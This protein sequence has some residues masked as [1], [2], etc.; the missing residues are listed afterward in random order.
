MENIRIEYLQEKHL[1]NLVQFY[2]LVFN[3]IVPPSY[4][5]IKYG[6]EVE[7]MP[8]YAT[9]IYLDDKMVGF[10]G[11]I[12]QEF[13]LEKTIKLV[14]TCDF[15]LLE[16]YRG[17]GLFKELYSGTLAKAKALNV[18]LFYGIHSVQS[19]KSCQRLG[20]E[21]EIGFSRFHIQGISP[22]ISKLVRK[23]LPNLQRK[24]LEKALKPYLIQ[25]EIDFIKNANYYEHS[26][27]ATFFEMKLFSQ[28]YWVMIKNIVLCIKLES[29]ASVGY[30]RI[31]KGS[32]IEEMLSVLKGILKRSLIYDLVFHIQENAFEAQK[33]EQFIKRE[34][35]FLVSA[36][37]LNP[38]APDFVKVKLNFMDMDIF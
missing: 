15:I 12:E 19:Y 29:Y 4:F 11:A 36:H 2:K 9:V 35:S 5:R 28:H 32:N 34:P 30:I 20:W 38:E 1:D 25:G 22:F 24:R 8:I 23:V 21:D 13:K 37:K 27:T 6:L 17:K 7:N 16:A 26:Y 33:I 18:D 31:E 3:S 14:Q 10:H